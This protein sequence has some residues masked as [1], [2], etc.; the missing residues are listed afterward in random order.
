MFFCINDVTSGHDKPCYFQRAVSSPQLL[1]SDSRKGDQIFM[2]D[3]KEI[4]IDWKGIKFCLVPKA[5]HARKGEN[6][7]RK[8]AD[9]F[10][11]FQQ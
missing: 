2:V 6:R 1:L 5:Q 8:G 10:A 3:R 9:F 11:L 7:D 4:G